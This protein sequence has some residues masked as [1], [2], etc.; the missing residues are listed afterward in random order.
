MNTALSNAIF[1]GKMFYLLIVDKLAYASKCTVSLL[2][3]IYIS[4]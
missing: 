2:S 1:F 3:A 4:F